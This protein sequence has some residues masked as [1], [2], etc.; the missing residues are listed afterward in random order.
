MND[1]IVVSCV[2]ACSVIAA[3]GNRALAQT[4]PQPI[5]T[6]RP[7]VTDSSSVVPLGTLQ[8]E[9]GFTDTANQGQQTVDGPETL[10]RFGVASTTELR[11]TVPDYYGALGSAQPSGF[12]DLGIGIKQQLDPLAGFDASLVLTLTLPTGAQ[13]ISSGGYDPWIQLPWSHAIASNWT[14]A[15]M[16]SVYWYDKDGHRDTTGEATFL[17]SRQLTAR[18]AGFAEYAGDF[19]E[20]GGPSHLLHF[21]TTYTVTPRQQLDLHV[22]VGLS[23]A[24]VGHFVGVGYSFRFQAFHRSQ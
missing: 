3:T 24:A 2:L 10:M 23:S 5:T 1:P 17:L 7:S 14:A 13:G 21:G 19:A 6:D 15:G 8:L 9:N 20:S 4:A 18:W 12:G 22:G 11:L 16:L